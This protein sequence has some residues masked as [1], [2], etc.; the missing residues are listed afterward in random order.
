VESVFEREIAERQVKVAT[1]LDVSPAPRGSGVRISDRFRLLGMPP[2]VAD[3]VGMGL[4]EG[5]FFAPS[6]IRWT[7]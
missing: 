3:A 7:M 4:R 6:A 2:D 5:A 1:V